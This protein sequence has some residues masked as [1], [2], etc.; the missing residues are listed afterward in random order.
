MITITA[1][2]RAKNNNLGLEKLRILFTQLIVE[3]RKESGCLKYDLHA[4]TDHPGLFIMMEEWASEAAMEFHN[5][6]KHFEDFLT[7]AE[8]HL[9]APLEE[10]QST[11]II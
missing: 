9:A 6:S 2:I 5:T 1:L 3:T 8:P 4:V 7:A 11:K 10:F